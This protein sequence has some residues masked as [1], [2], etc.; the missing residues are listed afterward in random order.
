MSGWRA[1]YRGILPDDFLAGLS[2]DVREIAWRALLET[3]ADGRAPAWVAERGRP[4]RRLRGAAVRRGTTTC[5]PPPPRST[6]STFYPRPGGAAPAGRCWHGG[7]PLARRR[8]DDARALGS[9]GQRAGRA[10]YEA[11]GWRPDGARQPL[12]LGGF[13]TPEIRY[14][15]PPWPPVEG[16]GRPAAGSAVI[17]RPTLTPRPR[18]PPDPPLSPLGPRSHHDRP[19]PA[20]LRPID[21]LVAECVGLL[22]LRPRHVRRAPAREACQQRLRLGVERNQLGV[23]DPPPAVELL[24]DQFRVEQHIH[25]FRPQL[26]GQG[27]GPQHGRVLGHVVGLDAQVLGDGRDRRRIRA[28]RGRR[29]PL[30][31]DRAQRRR[32]GV[33]AC[34]AVGADD[35]RAGPGAAGPAGAHP[36][37]RW[38]RPL[39]SPNRPIR[40]RRR[41]PRE[42]PSRSRRRASAASPHDRR[43]HLEDRPGDVDAARAGVDTVED[44]AAAPHA[45]LVGEDLQPLGRALVA[46]VEDEAV[47]LDD[48][49]RADVL[50]PGPEGRAGARAGGAQDALGGVVEDGPGPPGS[51]AARAPARAGR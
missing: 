42:S 17:G 6:R 14:P 35:Q 43:G 37:A 21:R 32:P 13:V 4:R 8:R 26:A 49:G 25:L 27:Q 20:G 5:R 22:V 15:A 39:P 24:H 9:R 12:D 48:G 50:G 7:G 10:F 45:V 28:S 1:A 40:R 23:L 46:R 38:Q 29:G 36:Q 30:D 2:V 47:G 3:D 33:A 19:G 31:Q 34:R 16:A 11:L 41:T 51:G 44:R 18:R